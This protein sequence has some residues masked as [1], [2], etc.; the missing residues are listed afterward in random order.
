MT[1]N[2]EVSIRI[3]VLAWLISLA[4]WCVL[5]LVADPQPHSTAR[6]VL[7]IGFV[8]LVAPILVGVAFLIAWII[9]ALISVLTTGKLPE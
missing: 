8:I 1:E 9:H 6:A 5:I 3:P 4:A 7:S 2:N